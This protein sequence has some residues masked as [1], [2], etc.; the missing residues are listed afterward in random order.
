[1]KITKEFI[2][3]KIKEIAMQK[4]VT[5]LPKKN[6]IAESG[7]SE[8]EYLKLF[9]TWNEAV[10]AAGLE[11]QDF[12]KPYEKENLF[13]NLREVFEK[14]E[15][16]CSRTKFN[17][18]SSISHD[19]YRRHFGSWQEALVNF[20][21]WLEDNK[22]DYPWVAELPD[23]IPDEIIEETQER[24]SEE[25]DFKRQWKAS[26]G[27]K[28]GSFLNFRGLQHAPINEQGVVFLFGMVCLEIGFIVEAVQ[29]G[30]PDCEAKR[31]I[32]T[33]KDHWERVQIEFEY[34]SSNF[35]EHGHNP[36][37]CDLIVC[38]EHNWKECPIEVIELRK[39]LSELED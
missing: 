11:T 13:Q 4:G 14:S 22:Y 33:K 25:T 15:G 26:T 31:R 19:S 27:N 9:N 16:L 18:I 29:S 2:I 38:W 1:M 17:K 10:T 5:S 7:I 12:A 6:F 36:T 35:Q 21:K 32:D 30:F 20:K 24:T 37:K 8:Y 39:V 34:R 23:D 28:Y 3:E